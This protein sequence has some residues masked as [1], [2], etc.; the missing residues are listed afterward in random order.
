[1]KVLQ[2]KRSLGLLGPLPVWGMVLVPVMMAQS[3]ARPVITPAKTASQAA[4]SSAQGG[5]PA[6]VSTYKIGPQD[7][8]Q[9]TVWQEPNLSGTFPVRPD[10]MISLVLLGD[11][12]AAG[13]TPMQLAHDL[14]VKLKKYIQDPV[15]SVVVTSVDSQRIYVV[16][17]VMHT[18]PIMMTPGMTLL[19][20]IASAGGLTPYT[21]GKHCYI[22]R[23][24]EGHEQKI[25]FNYKAAL[26]GDNKQDVP[27]LSGD[28][29]VVP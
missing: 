10:G 15:V 1:M 24:S 6:D 23:G 12:P 17:E 27:L 16:G 25:P 21:N 9:I 20:A 19:Q 29:I 18:G 11:V 14:T 28:T 7:H 3:L 22:L 8:L 5:V 13:L 2:Q 4:V 26:K